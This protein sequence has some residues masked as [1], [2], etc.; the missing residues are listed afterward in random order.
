MT[1]RQVVLPLPGRHASFHIELGESA[2]AR[3]ITKILDLK[4]LYEAE[5]LQLLVRAIRPGDFVIDC[6]ACTGLIALTM[7]AMGAT[8]LA[9]EP[10]DNNLPE[11]YHNIGLNKFNIDVRPVALGAATQDAAPFLLLDD[12]GVNSF[13][14]PVDRLPG[15]GA[16]VPVRRLPDLISSNPRL[17]KMDIEGSEYDALSAWLE[18]PWHCPYIAIEYNLTAL[19]RAGHTGEE[20]RAL[21]RGHGYEMWMLFSDGMLPMLVPSTTR[22]ICTRQNVNV[23]FATPD[24]VGLLWPEV[25]T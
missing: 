9:I 14:Q 3:T 1:L 20:L 12:G 16:C 10:G 23:L 21:M 2:Q 6:G 18:G 15:T 22:V 25:V 8:V 4:I 11:L 5:L 7:A 19:E 17:I 13:T 24:D